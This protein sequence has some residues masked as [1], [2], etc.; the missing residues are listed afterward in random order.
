MTIQALPPE[1]RDRNSA[2]LEV[3]GRARRAFARLRRDDGPQALLLSWP[4][5]VTSLPARLFKPG[6]F[7]VIVGHISGCPIH[8]DLRQLA[9]Y[10]DRSAVLDVLRSTR[11]TRPLARLR[12]PT[13]GTP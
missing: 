7:D 8:A 5:G 10:R 6:T 9:Y 3:T 12:P 11:R 1:K 4:S 2:R 13:D